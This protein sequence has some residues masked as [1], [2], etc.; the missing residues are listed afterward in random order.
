MNPTAHTIGSRLRAAYSRWRHPACEVLVCVYTCEA[1]A[2][3]LMQ[4]HE[5]ELGQF[6]SRW[7]GARLLEVY[8]D[9]SV[10]RARLVG[11]RLTIR[12]NEIY[13]EL[14]I[15][16]H[17]M[18][19]HCVRH[20]RFHRLLKIDVANVKTQLDDPKFSGR[21]PVNLPAMIEYLRSSDANKDYD[22]FLMHAR[23]R[24]ED[25]ERWAARKGATIDLARV[26]GDLPIPPYFGGL[27]YFLSR[28][29]ANYVAENGASVADCHARYLVGSEDVMI[30]RL[31]VDFKDAS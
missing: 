4:F 28:R 18:I 29:F 2:E 3:L 23:Q 24:R 22:G 20:F 6:L 15:K 10:P 9:A 19:E 30:G 14:S 5:S 13:G 16:T 11:N 7:P 26:F 17:R 27:C 25:V 8:A 1:D 12:A 21:K 31:F